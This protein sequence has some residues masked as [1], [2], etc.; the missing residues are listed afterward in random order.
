LWWC[1]ASGNVLLNRQLL[2]PTDFFEKY[3][4]VWSI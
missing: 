3:W 4:P 2:H 1:L